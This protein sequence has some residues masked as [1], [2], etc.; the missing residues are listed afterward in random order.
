MLGIPDPFPPSKFQKMDT[1]N[2]L[3]GV[4]FN[5]FFIFTPKIG[6]MIQF[7]LRIFFKPPTSYFFF[8]GDKFHAG[9]F[10]G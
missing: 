4:F 10:R 7:D 5:F 1:P 6:E 9:K 8:A 2:Y 3:G